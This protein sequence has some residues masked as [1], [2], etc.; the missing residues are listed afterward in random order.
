MFLTCCTRDPL[1]V[2]TVGMEEAGAQ[3]VLQ[4]GAPGGFPAGYPRAYPLTKP[5]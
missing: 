2:L 1:N 5:A 4:S 3:P